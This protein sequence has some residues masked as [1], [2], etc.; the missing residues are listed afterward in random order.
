MLEKNFLDIQDR[1][2]ALSSLN[3][4]NPKNIVLIAVSKS[5]SASNIESLYHLGQRDFGENRLH[6][7]EQK[8][9]P[10]K[11]KYPDI[12]LHLIGPLQTNKTRKAVSLFD[13]IHTVDREEIALNLCKE[14]RK[15][16]KKIPCFIQINIGDEPQ[17]SGIPIEQANTFIAYCINTLSMPIIGTMC[18]P[19]VDQDPG[20]FFVECKN[21]AYHHHL[22][23]CSMGMSNDFE[24]AIRLGAT[25]IRVGSALFGKRH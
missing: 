18:I 15:Q 16:D 11:I 22:E 5:V 6:E 8:F 19:P 13:V 2:H 17:K 14:M 20:S 3:P 4:T 9:I 10:L 23:Y 21:I 12:R 7:A 1:I 24:L 25:H